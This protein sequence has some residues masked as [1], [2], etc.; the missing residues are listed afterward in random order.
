MFP[1]N[2]LQKKNTV[3]TGIMN[4]R[5]QKT[6]YL[7]S[8]TNS[9]LCGLL[10]SEVN[11]QI[12]QLLFEFFSWW[13]YTLHKGLQC[14]HGP[15]SSTKANLPGGLFAQFTNQD[16]LEGQSQVQ[17]LQPWQSIEAIL[18]NIGE[19]TQ[20]TLL[21]FWKKSAFHFAVCFFPAMLYKN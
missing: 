1:V 12:F 16:L 19:L 4:V 9:L 5:A 7:S 6:T 17:L 13:Y 15:K 10:V 3:H 21:C 8:I 11:N 18:G 14:N 20:H 2:L